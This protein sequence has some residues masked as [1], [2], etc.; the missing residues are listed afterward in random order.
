MKRFG[1][2]VLAGAWLLAGSAALRAAD[3]DDDEFYIHYTGLDRADQLD[4]YYYSTDH[5]GTY[6]VGNVGSQKI[7][8]DI[9]ASENVDDDGYL[10]VK[11]SIESGRYILLSLTEGAGDLS[12]VTLWFDYANGYWISYAFDADRRTSGDSI[13]VNYQKHYKTTQKFDGFPANPADVVSG[14]IAAGGSVTLTA[15]NITQSGIVYTCDGWINGSPNIGSSGSSKSVTFNISEDA[16]LTWT[17]G[18]AHNLTVNVRPAAQ[19]ANAQLLPHASGGTVLTAVPDSGYMDVSAIEVITT[20]NDRY[21]CTGYD[22]GF[23]NVTP[24]SGLGTRTSGRVSKNFPFNQASGLDFVYQLQH[25]LSVAINAQTDV[26]NEAHPSPDLAG[27]PHWLASGCGVTARVDAVVFDSNNNR[28]VCTGWTGTGSAGTGTSAEAVFGITQQSSITWQYQRT[29][30]YTVLF[31]GLPLHLRDDPGIVPGKGVNYVFLN[32]QTNLIAT[33]I[34]YD[35]DTRYICEG[36]TA[37]GQDDIPASGD[38]T[39]TATVI[40]TQDST[41]TWNYRQEHRLLVEVNP[42]SRTAAADPLPVGTNWYTHGQ[43]VTATVIQTI[44]DGGTNYTCLGSLPTGS[45]VDASDVLAG[46]RLTRTFLLD[47][48]GRIIWLFDET[49]TWTVGQPVTPPPGAAVDQIPTISIVVP[50][51]VGD[52]EQ[53]TFFFGGPAGNKKLYPIRPI[54][55]AILYWKH[56]TPGSPDIPQSGISLWP[57]PSGLQLHVGSTPADLSTTTNGYTLVGVSHRTADGIASN[58]VF[59]ATRAGKTVVQFVQADTPDPINYPSRFIVV[60]T[61]LWNNPAYL[62]ETNWTIGT[63]IADALHN[64]LPQR[65]GYVFFESAYYDADAYLRASRKGPILPVNRDTND[66]D[67]DMVVVWYS[68]GDPELGLYWPTRPCRYQCDWPLDAVVDHVY[69][70]SQQGSGALSPITY[71]QAQIYVQADPARPGYNPNEEHAA[72]F[73]VGDNPAVFALRNDL[74]AYL[75]AS[76]PYV[77]LKYMSPLSSEW[78]MKVYKVVPQGGGFEFNY[79]ITAGFPILPPFPLSVLPLQDESYMTNGVLWYHRDHKDGHWA[80]AAASGTNVAEIVMHWYYPLQSG[81]YF[82]DFDHD[83]TPDAAE[84][85]PLPLL[86]G[87]ADLTTPPIDVTYTVHWPTNEVGVLAVGETLTK[88][89][90]GL[91]NIF[92]MACAEV[93]FDENLRNGGGPLV[94]LIDPLSERWVYLDELPSDILTEN[95][96]PR[97][98]F[99]DLPYYLKAR[100]SYD[101]LNKRL[102]FSGVLDESGVGE[103]LLLL[104]V[105]SLGERQL[106]Q[107]FSPDWAAEIGQLYE[108]SRNPN[109]VELYTATV[110]NPLDEADTYTPSQWVSLWGAQLGLSQD[111]NGVISLLRLVGL[112]KALTA[113]ASRGSGW[114]TFAENDDP[115]LGA[116]PV[117]LHVIRVEGEPYVGEI[118]VIESDNLF[119]EKL[120]LRHSGDFGGEPDA[121]VFEWY[122][123]PD[124]TGFAPDLPPDVPPGTPLTGW[125]LFARERGQQEITIEGASPLTLSD[126]WFAMRY[127]Y[128]DA[129]PFY[130]NHYFISR[131]AG[132]PGNQTAQLAEGWIKRVVGALNPFDARVTDFH[133]SPVNTVVSMIAQAGPRY[134]GAIAFN[135]D[136]QNLNSLGL[137]EAYD[138]VLRRGKMLSVDSGINYGPA[139]SALLNAATRLSDFYVLLGNEAYQDALD[140]TIGFGTDSGDYGTLAS[141]I[142]AFQNQVASLLEE[143]LVLLRGRDSSAAPTRARPV[144]NRFFWNFTQGDGEVAYAQTYNISDQITVDSDNNGYA[145]ATDGVIDEDDAKAMYPQGHGDAWGHYLSAMKY[146]YA[147][148]RHPNFSWEPRPE[149]VLVGGAAVTVDYLDERKFARAA[150]AKARV[151]AEIVDLTYRQHYVDDPAGQWQGYKDTDQ[152]R[153]WGLDGWARRAGQGAYFDWVV[154]NAILPAQ[155]PNTNHTGI[156]KVD[157]TTVP[158]LLEI[159]TAYQEIQAQIDKADKGLNPLGL[160]KGVVPFDIDPSLLTGGSPQTHFEQIYDRALKA[161]ANAVAVFDHANDLTRM[162]R[163][164]QDTLDD[165]TQNIADQEQDYLNRLI[166]VF[167]YP[168]ADDIGPS[169]AYP[170]GYDGPDWIHYMYVNPS[171]LTGEPI[172]GIQSYNVAYNFDTNT[173][174]DQALGITSTQMV[175]RYTFSD[176][177]HWMVTPDSWTGQRRAPGEIQMSISDLILAKANL[178]RAL[179]EYD[180]ILGGIDSARELL[181]AEYDMSLAE[182]QI[183]RNANNEMTTLESEMVAYRATT[184]ALRRVAD[185]SDRIFEAVIESIPK[186]AGLASDVCAPA[187]GALYGVRAL[188]GIIL[189]SVSDGFEVAELSA[190]LDRDAVA[191]NADLELMTYIGNKPALRERVEAIQAAADEAVL[192]RME[193]STLKEQVQQAVGRYHSAVARGQRILEERAAFRRS[194]APEIQDLRYQDMAFRVFRNDALQKYR[195]VLDLAARYVYMAA[196]A[197][198][199]ET[200]LLGGDNGAGRE[201]LA[202]I[203]RQRG[204]GQLLNGIPMAGRPGLADPLARL[205]QNFAVYKT[206]MGFNNPQTETSRFSL[207]QELFRIRSDAS[208]DTAWRNVLEEH[209]VA[210]LWHVPAFK[211][212]CRPFA[213]ENEGAQ[214]AIVI[215]FSTYVQYG[216]N[217]FGW[218]LAGGDSTYD[219]THFATKIR[220]VGVWFRNYDGQGLSYTP[221]VYLIPTGLDIMRSPSGD[222]LSTRE[223]KIVDQKIP[224]PFPIGAAD[225]EDQNWIPINDNLSDVMAAIRRFS[226]FRAYHDSGTFDAAETISDSRL[227]GRSVWNTQW[228]LVIPGETL[229]NPPDEGLDT[230]IYGQYLPDGSG[231]RDLNGVKDIKLF[232]QTYAYSGN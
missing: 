187:R 196:T 150:A 126:N 12:G 199:Y 228:L 182:L 124:T 207:R 6:Y 194:A 17:Y 105:L 2:V 107:A 31:N 155:D 47:E 42:D 102:Y 16:Y 197:Y 70:A 216:Q 217:F 80:K 125:T 84:G 193:L 40:V 22:T 101:P 63:A 173:A 190:S 111:T 180:Q 86:N 1:V 142:F 4:M 163:R 127:A 116:A 201:F 60:D 169:G 55:S 83:G 177:G 13:K 62:T 29:H 153:A 114:I 100:L 175:V 156:A 35:G 215:P 225:L 91:P 19:T 7:G 231:E 65:N 183:R 118:K 109:N 68:Q 152:D 161:M 92:G 32:S 76:Q 226:R 149:A 43:Q 10:F 18:P 33:P 78:A 21:Y 195:A 52:T 53:N 157:R 64:D 221:R 204:L 129:Y 167:G 230:F 26:Q 200:N 198:D 145:D 61:V 45:A 144:Y 71:P 94:K 176:D 106:L 186:V 24:S 172:E 123:K 54:T 164:N 212:F 192:K 30:A 36:W 14:W 15:T 90:P 220:T 34:I 219:P 51:E 46:S 11:Y 59:Y 122:Y 171:E 143:E 113:G 39:N 151:G 130:T 224:V 218:P 136:P 23:G 128:D 146:H 27:S 138:T 97:K 158:E 99:S 205:S 232:F 117:A 168:Y 208:S 98:R 160:A 227:I 48:P 75:G 88:A 37:S 115:S 179:S 223:W 103:P 165:F 159:S 85:E 72:L 44:N 154:A 206:Q 74:N 38:T 20:G 137:I 96:G 211:R 87:G 108:Q 162:L 9:D 148:L 49:E 174:I 66:D 95:D 222:T 178:E 189:N 132:A 41:I 69:I 210:D 57:A 133:A 119:D 170:S 112:P 8:I 89:K 185:S 141:S 93:I 229:L 134:E 79:P 214:P 203:V 110:V 181:E 50:A 139:N 5:G 188:I 3:L 121:M 147:L 25:A 56:E 191:R 82:P 135:G 28:W 73:P 58:K 81:W 77:L 184:V 202:N 140:P 166:E 104:N 131:W 67:D 209:R 120:T 213:P